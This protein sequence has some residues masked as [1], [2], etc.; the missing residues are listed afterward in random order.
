MILKLNAVL[1]GLV[2]NTEKMK[3]NIDKSKEQFFSQGL[4]LAMVKKG[5][6]REKAYKISQDLSFKAKEK[7]EYL[8]KIVLQDRQL[9][10]LFQE[11]ELKELFSWKRLRSNI[12]YIYKRIKD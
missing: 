12:D 7:N 11:K 2:V 3:E 10:I 4:M 9:K 5:L 6:S 1:Q 8:S